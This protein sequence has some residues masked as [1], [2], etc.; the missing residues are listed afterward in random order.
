MYS[1]ETIDSLLHTWAT[2]LGYAPSSTPC[3]VN[4]ATPLHVQVCA[5]KKQLQKLSLYEEHETNRAKLIENEKIKND[6]S[7][8]NEIDQKKLSVVIATVDAVVKF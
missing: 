7:Y 8:R 1:Y 3:T 5:E 4:W 2:Q 6:K